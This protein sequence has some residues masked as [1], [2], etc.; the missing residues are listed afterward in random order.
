MTTAA[1]LTALLQYGPTI[2]PL[3]AKL[4]ADVKSRGADAVVTPEDFA[5]LDRLGKQSAADIYARYGI[6]PPPAAAAP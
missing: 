5:E 2:I 1:L 6:T 3:A 4:V